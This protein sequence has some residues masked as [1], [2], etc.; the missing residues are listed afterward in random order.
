LQSDVNAAWNSPQTTQ[1]KS[2][3]LP[4]SIKEICFTKTGSD[5]LIT[6]TDN[7]QLAGIHNIDNLNITAMTP[8]GD[9]CFNVTNGQ[10]GLVLQKTFTDTLVTITK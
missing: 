9:S 8:R 5:N 6:Y 4:T 10:L 7:N 3:N 2:Y 1:T